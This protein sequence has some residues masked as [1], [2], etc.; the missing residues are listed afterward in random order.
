MLLRAPAQGGFT[1]WVNQLDGGGSNLAL[2]N[3]ILG[4]AEYGDRFLP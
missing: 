1:F 4:S 3:A 2:I